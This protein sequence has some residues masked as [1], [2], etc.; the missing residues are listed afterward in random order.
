MEII[1]IKTAHSNTNGL[2][3][4]VQAT[5]NGIQASLLIDT[6]AAVTIVSESIFHKMCASNNKPVLRQ[7]TNNTVLKTA[8]DN[9]LDVNGLATVQIE[10]SNTV[11]TWDVYVAPIHDDVLIGYDFLYHFDCVM[12]ARRGLRI[13]G[14]WIDCVISGDTK[15]GRVTLQSSIVVPANCEMLTAGCIHNVVNCNDK[16]VIIEPVP[17]GLRQSAIIVGATLCNAHQ[18]K[19]GVPVRIMNTSAEDISL[20]KGQTVAIASEVV[21][22]QPIDSRENDAKSI[23]NRV[24]RVNVQPHSSNMATGIH[25]HVSVNELHPSLNEMYEKSCEG[26]SDVQTNKLHE[27]LQKHSDTFAKSQHDLGRTSVLKH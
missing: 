9:L 11:F 8:D 24:S 19:S 4:H 27:L 25:E 21:H 22:I 16:G 12:E 23:I 3:A 14:L 10:I 18:I 6:G 26:L 7:P 2:S 17:S 5:V 20:Q 1:D 15:I 13:D